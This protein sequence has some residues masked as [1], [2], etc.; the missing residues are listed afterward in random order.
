MRAKRKA[1]GLAIT[2]LVAVLAVGGAGWWQYRNLV[3]EISPQSVHLPSPNAYEDYLA[4]AALLVKGRSSRSWKPATMASAERA[5]LL[6]QNREALERLR[7]GLQHEYRN[8]PPDP[9]GRRFSELE[10]F[11]TLGT[12]LLLEGEQFEAQR[13]W[14]EAAESYLDCLQLGTD[15]PRGGGTFHAHVGAELQARSLEALQNLTPCLDTANSLRV[16]RELRTLDR[17]NPE[18]REILVNEREMTVRFLSHLL[19][20]T[21]PLDAAPVTS[22]SQA[23]GP[24]IEYLLTPKQQVIQHYEGYMNGWIEHASQ[25]YYLHPPTPALPREFET[26]YLLTPNDMIWSHWTLRAAQWRVTETCL[27]ARAYEATRGE[28]P[29]SLEQLVPQYLPAVPQDPFAPHPLVFRR[30]GGRTLIY[31]RGPDGDDD[32]GLPGSPKNPFGDGD[33]VW[34]RAR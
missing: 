30:A 26:R 23:P 18:L 10:D 24:A 9:A 7:E 1:I 16:L 3:P 29:A 2:A 25:P 19:R 5:G 28:P 6:V 11:G 34:V 8:P 12:L 31:S 20:T 15:I 21:S 33:V 32:G 22:F 17:A 13:K 14:A 4:A 27:A